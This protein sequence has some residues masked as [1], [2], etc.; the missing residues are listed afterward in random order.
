M[1]AAETAKEEAAN[2]GSRTEYVWEDTGSSN[3][4]REPDSRSN[5]PPRS[6]DKSKKSKKDTI[7]NSAHLHNIIAAE[8]SRAKAEPLMLSEEDQA[9]RKVPEPNLGVPGRA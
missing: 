9:R 4:S 7:E 1:E 3:N 5:S 8:Q 2:K 6:A